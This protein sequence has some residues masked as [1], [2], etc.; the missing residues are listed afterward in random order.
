MPSSKPRTVVVSS[1]QYEDYDDCLE[2]AA[3]AYAGEH[4]LY[5]WQV[6]PEWVGGEDG[7]RDEILLTVRGG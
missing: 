7:D 2:M 6:T 3:A 5:T 4:G 1:K